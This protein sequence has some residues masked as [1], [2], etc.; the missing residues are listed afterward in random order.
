M[1][2]RIALIRN[3]GTT[4]KISYRM[5]GRN[6]R[7]DE[8]QAAILSVK[9]KHLD[10]W[11]EARRERAGWYREA[12]AKAGHDGIGL[13]EELPDRRHVYHLFIVRV[14]ERDRVH[15]E[16]NRRGIHTMVHYPRPIH[17][18]SLYEGRAKAGA[19]PRAEQ[20]AREVLSL[21]MYPEL[22]REAITAVVGA[23]RGAVGTSSGRSTHA[24]SVSR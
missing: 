13:P 20:A 15:E 8:L 17:L 9:L 3:Y 21:P 5:F 11:N 7:L 1:A 18:D 4:D 10:A 6:S 16:L 19:F 2:D 12:F 23:L 14:P 22:S 24:R